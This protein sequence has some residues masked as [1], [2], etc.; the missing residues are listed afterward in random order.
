MLSELL[1]PKGPNWEGPTADGMY[2][3]GG[4][5]FDA[6]ATPNSSVLDVVHRICPLQPSAPND[7]NRCSVG[8]PAVSPTAIPNTFHISARSNHTGGVNAAMCDGSVRFITNGIDL[9]SWQAL[10]T[11]TNADIPTAYY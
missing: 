6:V 4:Q 3:C 10:S 9:A 5:S 11:A 8:T 7:V 1:T 2:A